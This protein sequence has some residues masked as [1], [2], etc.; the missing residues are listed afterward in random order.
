MN[1]D[2]DSPLTEDEA[3][4]AAMQSVAARRYIER[5]ER[6]IAE[7]GTPAWTS[8]PVV[9]VVTREHGCC[10]AI[11]AVASQGGLLRELTMFYPGG[12]R[13]LQGIPYD[14][15]PAE[16][17]AGTWHFADWCPE[18]GKNAPA[19]Q[20]T[21][22][23]ERSEDPELPG[24]TIIVGEMRTLEAAR[25]ATAAEPVWIMSGI[26]GHAIAVIIPAAEYHQPGT[27]CCKNCPW[28][29]NHGTPEERHHG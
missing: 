2:P 25:A 1:T 24:R 13:D 20:E 10:N 21:T 12:H 26:N 4:E 19:R 3:R 27:C 11:Q 14:A 6:A 15:D 8:N 9:H 29:G 5:R 17:D 16:P 23:S 7:P 22:R 18:L 28:N